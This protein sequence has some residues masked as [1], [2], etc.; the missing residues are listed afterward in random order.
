VRGRAATV[1]STAFVQD[2]TTAAIAAGVLK[3]LRPFYEKDPI[4]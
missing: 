2:A 4:I 3:R 1:D